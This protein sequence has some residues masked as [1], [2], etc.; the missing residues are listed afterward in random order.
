MGW[1][2]A[3]KPDGTGNPGTGNPGNSGSSGGSQ[4]AAGAVVSPKT[5]DGSHVEWYLLSMIVSGGILGG[6]F[7]WNRKRKGVK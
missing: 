3:A 7:L 6:M 2:D 1:K 4:A 5:S